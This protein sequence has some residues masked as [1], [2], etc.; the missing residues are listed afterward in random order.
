M[1][2]AFRGKMATGHGAGPPRCSAPRT[3]LV[4]LWVACHKKRGLRHLSVLGGDEEIGLLREGRVRTVR[5]EGVWTNEIE[6]RTAS[7]HRTKDEASAV[8]R[9]IALDLGAEHV[10]HN[11]DGSIRSRTSYP[12][13]ETMAD[14]AGLDL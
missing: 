4:T 9:E 10:V 3:E 11:I 12:G 5:R 2:S 6:G 1:S 13:G 7:R 14:P 8:G